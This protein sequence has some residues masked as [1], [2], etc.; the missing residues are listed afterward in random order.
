MSVRQKQLRVSDLH[1]HLYNRAL[2]PELFDIYHDHRIDKGAYKAQ[3]WVT[4]VSHVVGFYRG[5]AAITELLASGDTRLPRRGLLASVPVRGEKD[6]EATH[7]QG[8]HYMTSFQVERMSRRL[9]TR[10]HEDIIDRGSAE[11]LFVPFPEWRVGPLMPLTHIEYEAKA[12]MLHVFTFHAFPEEFT[13][14]KTQ[15]IFELT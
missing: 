1:F 14:I 3:I 10:T 2:H 5:D 13:V 8:I 6:H 11:G 12:D 4:G 7:D 9:F 15:S